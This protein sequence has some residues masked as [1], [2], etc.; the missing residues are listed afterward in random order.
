MPTCPQH[1]VERAQ[2]CCTTIGAQRDQAR[3]TCPFGKGCCKKPSDT[4]PQHFD[5]AGALRSERSREAEVNYGPLSL[6]PYAGAWFLPIAVDDLLLYRLER[7]EVMKIPHK[8]QCFCA[9]RVRD[10]AF[11]AAHGKITCGATPIIRRGNW[12]WALSS[13]RPG[14]CRRGGCGNR[15]RHGP[16]FVAFSRPVPRFDTFAAMRSVAV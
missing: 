16:P 9:G 6:D 1:R 8:G 3:R 12:P 13:L 7:Y 14:L 10:T 4:H 5:A 15:H 2:L 11:C